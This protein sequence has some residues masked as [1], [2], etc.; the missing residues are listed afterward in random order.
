[1]GQ[2]VT[3]IK[4][5][6]LT[7]KV[8]IVT[9]ANVG[10]GFVTARELAKSKAHVFLACRNTENGITACNKIKELLGPDAKVEALPLDL[11]SLK[12]VRECAQTFRDKKLPLHILINNAGIMN[13]PHSLTVD[14]IESQFGVNHIG[15]F[16]LTMSLLDI[17]K[18]SAP[19]RIVNLSSMAHSFGSFNWEDINLQKSYYSWTAYGRSKLANVLFTYELADRLKGT[20]VTCN[21]VH[22]G[23]VKT[24]LA[25]HMGSL[26]DYAA[27]LFAKT[28]DVG[29]LTQL[30]VATDPDLESVT[31]KYFAN[32]AIKGSSSASEN[33]DSQKKLWEVSL[34]LTGLNKEEVENK[35]QENTKEE[36]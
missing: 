18:A 26:A 20:G 16:L 21:A 1:M 25:R 29:A 28:V 15:H 36:Q 10:L 7:G 22:P 6:D 34:Q 14:G 24:E 3:T 30:Y 17:I 8:A 2:T 35:L 12:S 23:Y 11:G 9:G 19:S 4:S 32:C 5:V 33:K 13:V 27:Q 31:H